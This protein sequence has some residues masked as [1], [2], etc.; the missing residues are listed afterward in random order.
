MSCSSSPCRQECLSSQVNCWRPAALLRREETARWGHFSFPVLSSGLQH[1]DQTLQM[2]RAPTTRVPCK[3]QS[4]ER[5]VPGTTPTPKS[6]PEFT[7]KAAFRSQGR[8]AA[9]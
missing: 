2:S 6:S 8:E 3:T 9:P 1:G 7:H 5:Q 4:Q